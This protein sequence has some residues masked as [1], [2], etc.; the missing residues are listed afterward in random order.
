MQLFYQSNLTINTTLLL[1][2]D[3]S[4]H[5]AQ[6]LRLKTGDIIHITNGLGSLFTAELIEVNHKKCL[7][8]ITSETKHPKEADYSLHLAIAP[9]KNMDRMEWF[10]EKAVELGIDEVTPII[11]ARSERKEIKIERM[12]KVVIS[13]MKQSLKYH[14]PI[15]NEAISFNQFMAKEHHSQNFI[16]YGES[17]PSHNLS[18]FKTNKTHNLFLIGPEGDFTPSEIENA[19]KKG[20]R[21]LNLGNSRLRTETAALHVVSIVN[22]KKMELP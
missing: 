22:F 19:L 10:L 5:C 3:E 21:P 8:T 17:A 13:A 4:R 20:Y 18:T 12:N 2:E 1:N 9:T 6:V 16:C 14:L 15:I 11:C 7:I